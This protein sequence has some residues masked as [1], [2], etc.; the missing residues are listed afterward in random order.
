M[1]EII[2]VNI[3]NTHSE[4]ALATASGLDLHAIVATEDFAD[5]PG[6]VPLLAARP[7]AKLFVACVVPEAAQALRSVFS[8]DRLM[9]LNA[10]DVTGIE[11]LGFSADTLGADR[12]A[13]AVGI[14][15]VT[16]PPVVVLDCGTAITSEAVDRQRRFRGGVIL[17]GRRMQRRALHD[18]T[19]QLPDVELTPRPFPALGT[20][21][22]AS[23]RAGVDL[24]VLG[25]VE[26]ILTDSRRELG[27]AEC[28]VFVTGGDAAFFLEH[29]SD[30]KPAPA[31]L[32]L[33]GLRR[34]AIG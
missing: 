3:G 6:S 8:D 34:V 32:T 16:N 7:T 25:A 15:E 33:L 4:L 20:D 1:H 19:A 23:I 10:A 17:P 31:H 13:N 28:P 18:L 14:V 11:F 26:R 29:L 12:V 24:G 9:F 22:D 27:D 21:T 2:V 5:D 30:V